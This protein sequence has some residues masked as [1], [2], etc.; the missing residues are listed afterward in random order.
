MIMRPMQPCVPAL[1]H[2]CMQAARQAPSIIV[3]D[4]LDGLA[5]PH[6]HRAGFQTCT[7]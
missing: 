4:E 2:G 6:S 3:L 7:M 5:P 1:S